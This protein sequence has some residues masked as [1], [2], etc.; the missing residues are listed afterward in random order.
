M[1][2]YFVRTII[3]GYLWRKRLIVKG[4]FIIN[5]L[6]IFNLFYI[7]SKITSFQ[8]LVVK[9]K[10]PEKINVCCRFNNSDDSNLI[11]ATVPPYSGTK[12]ELYSSVTIGSVLIVQ[13]ETQFFEPIKCLH[14]TYKGETLYKGEPPYVGVSFAKDLIA[15]VGE[16]KQVVLTS[17]R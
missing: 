9:S 10:L 8:N 14:L 1:L 5:F 12:T 16:N 4:I 17:D 2:L 15:T 13:G 3:K 7:M 6:Q 11:K